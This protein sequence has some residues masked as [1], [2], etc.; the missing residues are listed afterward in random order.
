MMHFTLVQAAGACLLSYTGQK[1]K[2]RDRWY[3]TCF[4]PQTYT[5]DVKSIIDLVL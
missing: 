3:Q 2:L 4:L 1:S 5:S